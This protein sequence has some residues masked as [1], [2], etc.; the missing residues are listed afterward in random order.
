M[1]DD[2]NRRSGGGLM[3]PGATVESP[4][5]IYKKAPST[6]WSRSKYIPSEHAAKLNYITVF[7]ETKGDLVK[8]HTVK[9]MLSP[10][11]TKY[12][13]LTTWS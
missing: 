10:P 2:G 13:K 7:H 9:K 1:S 3:I 8:C 4:Q 5:S 6:N 12:S 11:A